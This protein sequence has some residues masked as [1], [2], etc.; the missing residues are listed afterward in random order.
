MGLLDGDM[1]STLQERL[2]VGLRCDRRVDLT[3]REELWLSVAPWIQS[4]VPTAG[5]EAVE[6]EMLRKFPEMWPQ[7][8]QGEWQAQPWASGQRPSLV[9]GA[10]W[11][12]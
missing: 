5:T 7:Y 6:A 4:Y 12:R 8:A 11:M 3:S 1:K 2:R 10:S 9:P